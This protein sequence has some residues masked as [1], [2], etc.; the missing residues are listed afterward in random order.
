MTTLSFPSSRRRP[1]S[2]CRSAPAT[3]IRHQTSGLVV[4]Y[5][6]VMCA[7]VSGMRHCGPS[8]GNVEPIIASLGCQRH[9]RCDSSSTNYDDLLTQKR[10]WVSAICWWKVAVHLRTRPPHHLYGELVQVS[11][12][13]TTGRAAH[14]HQ[15]LKHYISL[16]HPL[17][18]QL[19]NIWNTLS[20]RVTTCG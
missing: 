13:I 12:S 11:N 19:P 18:S 14:T 20:A 16:R 8:V 4:W 9:A 7:I 6:T 15:I 17:S 1:E 10:L 3:Q 5:S 2:R